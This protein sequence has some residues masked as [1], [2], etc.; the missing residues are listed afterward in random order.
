MQEQLYS[1]LFL[2]LIFRASYLAARLG[3]GLTG[4]CCRMFWLKRFTACCI[5]DGM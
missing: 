4:L 2:R 1:V 5:E 3:E